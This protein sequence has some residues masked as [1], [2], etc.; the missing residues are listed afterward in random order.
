M[1]HKMIKLKS[2]GAKDLIYY[3]YVGWFEIIGFISGPQF[4]YP[5]CSYG[6]C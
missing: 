3:I 2:K 1:V 4:R 5:R 6:D